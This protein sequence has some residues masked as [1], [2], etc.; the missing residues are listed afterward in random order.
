MSSD[1]CSAIGAPIPGWDG[2]GFPGAL[3]DALR[4]RGAEVI[5]THVDPGGAGATQCPVRAI[6]RLPR[7]V[8]RNEIR[9]VI[10][11]QQI[12]TAVQAH[13]LRHAR[14]QIRD[15]DDRPGGDG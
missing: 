3:A 2:T 6:P 13:Q 1:N 8:V 11:G 15:E 14:R 12:A 7:R 4:A 10:D 5:I 9:A